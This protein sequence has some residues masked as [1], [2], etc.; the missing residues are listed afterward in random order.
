MTQE[1]QKEDEWARKVIQKNTE[2]LKELAEEKPAARMRKNKIYRK[3]IKAYRKYISR[4]EEKVSTI[5][6]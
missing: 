3:I 4:K 2:G 6:L 5:E 1:N